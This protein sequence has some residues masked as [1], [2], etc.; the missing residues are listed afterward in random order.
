MPAC[1]FTDA[2]ALLAAFKWPSHESTSFV[3]V[4]LW[5][6]AIFSITSYFALRTPDDGGGWDEADDELPEPP[7]WPD[8][9][10]GFRD[11]TSGG[12]K[13]PAKPPRIPTGAR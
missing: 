3:L 2:A 9:E 7:W 5:L 1:F 6:A 8:F 13:P 4:L 11:Y 12:P 10:R